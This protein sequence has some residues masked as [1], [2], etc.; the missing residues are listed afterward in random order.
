MHYE[1]RVL[2]R[3]AEVVSA[4]VK[5]MIVRDRGFGDQKLYRV[6]TEELK[7]RARPKPGLDQA[8]VPAPCGMLLSRLS[9]IRSV[10]LYA[11]MPKKR[12]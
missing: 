1:Y 6:L 12:R 7:R 10:P 5:V 3:L 8:A 11:S 4:D 2:V 9:A